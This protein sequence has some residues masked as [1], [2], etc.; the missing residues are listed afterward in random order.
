MGHTLGI[1]DLIVKG[2][3][4]QG[5]RTQYLRIAIMY[6]ILY[7]IQYMKWVLYYNTEL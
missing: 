1:S 3:M 5:N 4:G 2:S 6:K 7:M